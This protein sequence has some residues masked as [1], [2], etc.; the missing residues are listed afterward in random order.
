METIQV[1]LH[2]FLTS[3][4]DIFERSTAHR[5]EALEVRLRTFV[6]SAKDTFDRSTAH[7]WRQ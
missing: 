6:T 4:S 2:T 5:M 1:Q 7:R 3:A